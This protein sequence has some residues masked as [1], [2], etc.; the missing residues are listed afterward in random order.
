MASNV[1]R[2][3][4][5]LKVKC[6]DVRGLI[7][8]MPLFCLWAN[9]LKVDQIDLFNQRKAWWSRSLMTRVDSVYVVPGTYHISGTWLYANV[10][11]AK[12][13]SNTPLMFRSI[14]VPGHQFSYE[15]IH[16]NTLSVTRPL[17]NA[18]ISRPHLTHNIRSRSR[19]RVTG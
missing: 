4:G 8:G 14:Q 5:G 6:S 12:A 13:T 19:R 10:I 16:T 15:Y 17:R 9:V 7:Y 18:D 3:L 1:K 11:Q 2:G